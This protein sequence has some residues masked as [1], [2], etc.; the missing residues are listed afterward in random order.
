MGT[1]TVTVDVNEIHNVVSTDCIKLVKIAVE[2]VQVTEAKRHDDVP[3]KAVGTGDEYVVERIVRQKTITKE[4]NVYYDG[5][6]T[7]PLMIH[8][9]QA[10]VHPSNLLNDI[11]NGIGVQNNEANR[12]VLE[13]KERNSSKQNSGKVLL[14]TSKYSR[15]PPTRGEARRLR[16]K[17]KK[18][19]ATMDFKLGKRKCVR[20]IRTTESKTKIGEVQA[21][22]A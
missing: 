12:R 8:E 13:T 22:D 10:S 17:N 19:V 1:D 9:N 4:L 16:T 2:A 20:S 14:K 7:D 3:L 11:E 18:T 6:T 21:R 15:L 5:T